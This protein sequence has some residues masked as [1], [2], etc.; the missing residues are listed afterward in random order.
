M[1]SIVTVKD[2]LES[3]SKKLLNHNESCNELSI[4][5]TKEQDSIIQ[6][7]AEGLLGLLEKK[8]KLITKLEDVQ[9]KIN[10]II[11]ESLGLE[12][13]SKSVIRFLEKSKTTDEKL[14]VIVQG[15]WAVFIEQTQEI[16][17]KNLVNGHLLNKQN[18]KNQLLISLLR[19]QKP[20][21]S[22]Y[23]ENGKSSRPSYSAHLGQA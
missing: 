15:L 10:V 18:A 16:E 9:L 6:N 12:L 2:Y 19:G 3:L 23:G 8:Q 14:S 5:L 1:A 22:L 11:K 20:S 17:Q 13:N 21:A 4:I 7:D